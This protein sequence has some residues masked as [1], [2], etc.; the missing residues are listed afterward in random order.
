MAA[1]LLGRNDTQ[2]SLS[3]RVTLPP[4]TQAAY[5]VAW[6]RV[7]SSEPAAGTTLY[8]TLSLLLPMSPDLSV[9]EAC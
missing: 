5:L 1:T 2:G 9:T 4:G 3:Q 7:E 8:G 6:W